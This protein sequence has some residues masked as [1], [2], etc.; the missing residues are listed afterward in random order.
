MLRMPYKA[1]FGALAILVSVS[2]LHAKDDKP[3]VIDA[4]G[5][6]IVGTKLTADPTGNLTM[7]I[8]PVGQKFPRG[9]YKFAWVPMP[10]E[11]L[12][13]AK[14]LKARKLDD[15][16]SKFSSAF[17]KYKYLGWAGYTA[18]FKGTIEMQQKRFDAAEKTFADAL[19][20][21]NDAKSKAKLQ[22]GQVEALIAQNKSDAAKRI[23]DKLK[24]SDPD[25]ATYVFNTRGA[26]L[27]A[28]GKKKE[29]VLQYLKTILLFDKSVGT[30]R[31][32]AY[33]QAIGLM[34]D[35]KDRRAAAFKAKYKAEYG[36]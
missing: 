6:K 17:N 33:V 13:A 28:E 30:V 18:Y 1:I 15:A 11:V 8:G 25:V 19:R 31:S 3:Y 21:N 10:P 2:S 4:R 27:K 26:M 7:K 20:Y 34:D 12:A 23:L 36:R 29:A 16:L 35:L 22:K 14:S 5:E 32:E 24:S 9:R